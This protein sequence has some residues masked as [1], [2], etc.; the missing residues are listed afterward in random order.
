LDSEGHFLLDWAK[1]VEGDVVVSGG[2]DILIDD[3]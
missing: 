1:L 3:S 2:G